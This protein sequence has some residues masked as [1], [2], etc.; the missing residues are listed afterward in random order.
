MSDQAIFG[1]AARIRMVIDMATDV[2]TVSRL[3]EK[4]RKPSL[5]QFRYIE[6]HSVAALNTASFILVT[7]AF[8]LN[9]YIVVADRFILLRSSTNPGN[10]LD[11][12]LFI[13]AGGFILAALVTALFAVFPI[14]RSV[15]FADEGE[16][17]ELHQTE[18]G[19]ADNTVK[20]ASASNK[21]KGLE[22]DDNYF[23]DQARVSL[24]YLHWRL[25]LIQVSI[26]FI[27][28]GIILCVFSAIWKYRILF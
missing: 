20:T 3:D 13:I 10:Y 21:D 11:N 15:L 27:W 6:R 19:L 8:L 25:R 26:L 16:Y 17:I 9:V 7:T 23:P 14:T 18:A 1:Q 22:S 2:P 24:R 12:I 4:S 5:G 28:I